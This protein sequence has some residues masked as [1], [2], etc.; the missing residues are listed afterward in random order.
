MNETAS[1]R[2]QRQQKLPVGANYSRILE[3]LLAEVIIRGEL[4]RLVKE[5]QGH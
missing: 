2:D 4:D 3:Q 5:R 1:W